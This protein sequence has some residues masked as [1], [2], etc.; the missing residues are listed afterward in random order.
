[1]FNITLISNLSHLFNRIFQ[2]TIACLK[3][4]QGPEIP[5][6]REKLLERVLAHSEHV[7]EPLVRVLKQPEHVPESL[8][9]VLK[10]PEH[11]LEHLVHVLIQSE[12]VPEPLVRVLK[13]RAQTKIN[14]G[15]VRS[16]KGDLMAASHRDYV[17]QNA[18]LFLSFLNQQL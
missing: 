13:D 9:H 2:G 6:W 4:D 15:Y 11:V 18:T 12:H 14:R 3:S 10:Q 1:M 16:G 7:L 8:V 5:R 17:P